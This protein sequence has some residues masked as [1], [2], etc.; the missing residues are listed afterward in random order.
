MF[1]SLQ[2]FQPDTPAGGHAAALVVLN[3][4]ESKRLIAKGVAAL[5]EVKKALTSGT[6]IISRGIT[7]A[8]VAEEITGAKIPLKARYTIG[9][10]SGGKLTVNTSPDKLPAYVLKDGKPVRLPPAEALK[11]FSGNDVFIKGASAIDREGNAAVLVSHENGGTMGESFGIVTARGARFI[12]P[13]GLEKLVPSVSKALPKCGTHRF[14]YATGVP[15]GLFPMPNATVVTEIQALEVL[16][17]VMATQ[18]A[19][20]GFAGSE[21][22]VVLAIE[23]PEPHVEKAFNLVQSIK[24]EPPDGPPPE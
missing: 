12:V 7:D 14:K 3:V 10:V 2:A 23:G 22:A 1:Y 18:V 8:Y 16:T 5:P 24:G 17:G 19:A 6:I 4:S 13:V 21:G 20:G 11:N 9:C 15:C